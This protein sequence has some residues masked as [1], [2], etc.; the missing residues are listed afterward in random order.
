MRE[1][2]ATP[3]SPLSREI[4]ATGS[5]IGAAAGLPWRYPAFCN[6]ISKAWRSLSHS[7][8]EFSRLVT[9]LTATRS[10]SIAGAGVATCATILSDRAGAAQPATATRRPISRRIFAGRSLD[11][12]VRPQ[13]HRLRDGQAERLGGLQIDDQLELRGLLDRQVRRLRALE[14]FIDQS[15]RTPLCLPLNRS[16]MQSTNARHLH[17]PAFAR[18]LHTP[19]FGCVFRQ[20]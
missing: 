13:Q 3:M 17:H 5:S 18:Q 10:R 7:T 16:M 19:R 15:C 11:N 20:R 1:V 9:S 6:D 12:L 2:V 8:F 14:D 4:R